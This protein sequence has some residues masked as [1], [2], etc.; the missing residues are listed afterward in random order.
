MDERFDDVSCPRN[1]CDF[2]LGVQVIV[3]PQEHKTGI[4]AQLEAGAVMRGQITDVDTG[5]GVPG[6]SCV[7]FYTVDG[8]YATFACSNEA[9]HYQS[10]TGLPD[11]EYL[12]SNQFGD[13]PVPGGFLPQVWT[14]D[15]SFQ[16]CGD[17]CDFLLGDP[18]TVSGT[19]PVEGINLV[20]ESGSTIPGSVSDAGL[21]ALSGIEVQLLSS[22]D[23]TVIYTAYTDAGGTYAFTGIGS[24]TYH[25]RT[26]PVMRTCSMALAVVI[27]PAIPSAT[28]CRG[29]MSFSM[30][31]MIIRP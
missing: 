19:A 9:G 28:R 23:G 6:G 10:L 2:N 29:R 24:G 5:V 22:I 3:G 26:S 31:P 13:A 25:V 12:M 20:M 7:S 17:P 27:F 8:V 16:G 11:G 21:A 1:S 14:N 18:I 15:G 30:A 4:D